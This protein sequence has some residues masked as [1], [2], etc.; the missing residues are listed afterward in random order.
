MARMSRHAAALLL[1]TFSCCAL[2]Q[3]PQ[4]DGGTMERGV[5]PARWLSQEPKCM[6]IPEWQVH[7]YNPNLY[8]LRQSPCTDFEKPFIFLFFGKDKALLMDTGSR[9]GDLTPTLR[10]T[11]KNW[12]RRNGRASIPLIVVHSHP[13]E[14]HM[15]GDAEVQAMHDPAIPVEFVPAG[16]EATKKFWG[17]ERWPT[18][19]GHVDLGG[20]VIDMVPIPGHSD[21]SV[22]LY[23]RNTALLLP[24]DSLYPGRLYVHDFAAF[25][26]STERLIKF[27]AGKPVA[28]ILGNH[29]EQS[30]TPFLDYPVGTM[31][32]PNE[33]ELALSR[34]S[35]LELEDALLS[36]NGKAQRMAMRDFSVWPVGTDFMPPEAMKQF[37]KHQAEEKQ[38][39]WDHSQ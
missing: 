33:H 19:I 11:V 39:M 28:H 13:H 26:A 30:S 4:P 21:V 23:D 18:D 32:Q 17:I 36:M 6:E 34:G 5:L 25:Q 31:Y 10:R 9:N 1:C 35:L 7:E 14:D 12:L 38:K 37:E 27:T 2:A 16:L 24:G 8:L 15:A 3:L 29:I 20:R 22:A